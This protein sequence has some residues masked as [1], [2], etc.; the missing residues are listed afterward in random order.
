MRTESAKAMVGESDELCAI[1]L[2]LRTF[3]PHNENLKEQITCTYDAVSSVMTNKAFSKHKIP[4]TQVDGG[5]VP[6]LKHKFFETDLPFGLCTFK[7]IANMIEV[8]VPGIDAMI[9]WNQLL[10]GKEYL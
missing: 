4:H 1:V 7:D 6:T 5:V 8:P 3:L 10:I 2:K 9:R